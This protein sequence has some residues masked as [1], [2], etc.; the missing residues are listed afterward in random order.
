MGWGHRRIAEELDRPVDT[1][2]GWLRRFSSRAERLRAAFTALLVAFLAEPTI[3]PAA[4]GTPLRDALSAIVA[5]ARVA[6]GRLAAAEPGGERGEA[7]VGTL[8]IWPVACAV[9]GGCLLAPSWN[10]ESIN[11]SCPLG[12]AW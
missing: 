10:P 3:L 7:F 9:S 5:L 1:V 4:A 6:L 12:A 11:T 8:P 2:R